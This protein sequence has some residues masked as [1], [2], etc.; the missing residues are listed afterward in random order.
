MKRGRID[1][2]LFV[3]ALGLMLFSLVV[4]F[5]ASSSYSEYKTGYPDTFFNLHLLKVFLGFIAL[6]VFT[7]IKIDFLPSLSRLILISAVG[8]L[9]VTLVFGAIQGLS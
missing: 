3:A 6:A 2:I 1:I 4:V 9:I 5:S 7:I 8:L